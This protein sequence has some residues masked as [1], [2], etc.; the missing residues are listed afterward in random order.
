MWTCDA[1]TAVPFRYGVERN[2]L[3]HPSFSWR[4]TSTE[5]G[6]EVPACS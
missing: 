5:S 4:Q 3:P 2:L 6:E 1:V